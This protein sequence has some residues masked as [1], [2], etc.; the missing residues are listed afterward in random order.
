MGTLIHDARVQA[1]AITVTTRQF[2]ATFSKFLGVTYIEF[3]EKTPFD[4]RYAVRGKPIEAVK[5]YL[6]TTRRAELANLQLQEFGFKQSTLLI[7]EWDKKVT[8]DN[9]QDSIRKGLELLA[10]ARS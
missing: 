3:D 6:T 2:L 1:P 9:Y 4:E 5:A 8:V 10:V 7:I